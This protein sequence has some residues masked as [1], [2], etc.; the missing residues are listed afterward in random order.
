LAELTGKKK[1]SKTLSAAVEQWIDE[2]QQ[3]DLVPL[4]M[5]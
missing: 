5:L 3:W 4:L 2:E 1:I